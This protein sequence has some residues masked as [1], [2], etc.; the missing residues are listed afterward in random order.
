MV[1]Q[2]EAKKIQEDICYYL[3]KN[4]SKKGNVQKA[5]S[6][7]RRKGVPAYILESYQRRIKVGLST[8]EIPPAY[9]N[10]LFKNNS[11]NPL[12]WRIPG[13]SEIENILENPAPIKEIKP[14]VKVEKPHPQKSQKPAV[15]KENYIEGIQ[16]EL[17][18][19]LAKASEQSLS[20]PE[21][22]LNKSIVSQVLRKFPDKIETLELFVKDDV[23]KVS[24]IL[25]D[26]EIT[27]EKDS[28]DSN[29]VCF[30]LRM[31]SNDEIKKYQ[32][33]VTIMRDPNVISGVLN[34]KVPDSEYFI[35]LKLNHD[36]REISISRKK[37]KLFMS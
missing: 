16:K 3:L 29:L 10:A 11:D 30:N 6:D 25:K 21:E 36:E 23:N 8:N 12:N 31:Y 14:A 28:G 32:K 35:V 37:S 19:I 4:L 20:F 18:S 9:I 5:V 26:F 2:K 33:Y 7:A 27:A 22:I 1:Y 34:L 24:P 15:K 13:T 17:K